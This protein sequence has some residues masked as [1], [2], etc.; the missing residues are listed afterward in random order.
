MS[1]VAVAAQTAPTAA[2]PPDGAAPPT[3]EERVARVRQLIAEQCAEPAPDL[4]GPR[5][6]QWPNWPNWLNGWPNWGNFWRN[7]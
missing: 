7:F 3:I 5:T 2:R 1:T 4:H 6:A